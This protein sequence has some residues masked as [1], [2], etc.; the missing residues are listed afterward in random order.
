MENKSWTGGIYL[1]NKKVNEESICEK[2]HE[3]L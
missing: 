2:Q 1:M 3:E